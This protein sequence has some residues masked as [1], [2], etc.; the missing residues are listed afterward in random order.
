MF[1]AGTCQGSGTEGIT[2]RPVA[3][4]LSHLLSQVKSHIH[5]AKSTA[6]N[7]H[8]FFVWM[9]RPYSKTLGQ[10]S[11]HPLKLGDTAPVSLRD[12]CLPLEKR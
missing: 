4:C 8:S 7:G 3:F 11:S 9:S 2:D 6:E 5:I 10:R 12:L 1:H